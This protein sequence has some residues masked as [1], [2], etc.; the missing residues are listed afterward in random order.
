V[1]DEEPREDGRGLDALDLRLI[2]A[3]ERRG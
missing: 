3:A 2:A 1:V